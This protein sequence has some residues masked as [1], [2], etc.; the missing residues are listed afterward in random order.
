MDMNEYVIREIPLDE[1]P[2][3]SPWPSRLLGHTEW[4][5]VTRSVEKIAAEYD[6]DKYLRC[7][8]F[9][10]H[11]G[12]PVTMDDVKNF[13]LGAPHAPDRCVSC[14]NR[15]FEM[16]ADRVISAHT[17]LLLDT[18]EPFMEGIDTV[19]EIGCGY[20]FN[21]WHLKERFPEKTY[22]GGEY[23]GNAITLSKK[24]LGNVTNIS[25]AGCNF[26]DAS[27]D[28]LEQC[29]PRSRVLVLTRHAIEQLPTAAPFLKTIERYFD[30]IAAV[31]H[32]EMMYGH[33]GNSLLGLLRRRYAEV[34]D[35]NR[36]VLDLLRGRSDVE[37][38]AEEA[39]LMGIAP[40]NPTSLL[41]WR[42]RK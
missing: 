20:G 34:N 26:Y 41:V 6:R 5:T 39:D 15:L 35:Y 4:K 22:I 40:L 17:Q 37:I 12:H 3:W 21:L 10:E 30:R 11:A 31:C 25:V 28:V 32:L 9:V 38:V 29:S 27:Y 2:Q 36:D 33:Y 13:E 1:L 16:R 8:E 7:L 24:L 18:V 42:P 14:R 23:S 19:V